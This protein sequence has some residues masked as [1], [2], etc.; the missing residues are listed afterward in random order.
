MHGDEVGELLDRVGLVRPPI[1][2]N[3]DTTWPTV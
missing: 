3:D 1:N 2:L